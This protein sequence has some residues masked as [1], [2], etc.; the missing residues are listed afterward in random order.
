MQAAP[1]G[2][3]P[4]VQAAPPGAPPGAQAAPPGVP[5]A[6]GGA[7]AAAAGG[8]ASFGGWTVG[9]QGYTAPPVQRAYSAAQTQLALRRELGGGAAVADAGGSG[10]GYE[11]AHVVEGLSALQDAY[12]E[13]PAEPLDVAAIKERIVAALTATGLPAG[14]IDGSAADA[15]EVV[16]GLFSSLLQDALIASGAKEHLTR[17]QP[18]VHRAAL[19]DNR[20]FE[21]PDHPVRL[22]IDRVARLRDGKSESVQQRQARVRELIGRAN[23]EFR[24]DIGIFDPVLEEIESLLGEQES[25][26][27]DRVAAVVESCEEQQRVLE[28]R[29]GSS[30]ESTDSSAARSDLPEEWHKWLDRARLLEVG[31]RMLMNA[32]SARPLVVSLVWKEPRNNLFVFVDELGNKANTLTQQQVAMYLRRGILRALGEDAGNPALERAMFGVVD[33]F[34]RQVEEEATRDELTGFLL[35]RFFLEAIDTALPEPETASARNAAVCELAIDNLAEVN[36]AYGEAVGD[37]LLTAL[38]GE[39]ERRVRGRNTVF[40]RLGGAALG[41]YWPNGGVAGAERKL[42]TALDALR[43][44]VVPSEPGSS[45]DDPDATVDMKASADAQT[46]ARGVKAEFVIGLTGTDDGLV[47]AEG[48]VAAAHD[49]CAAARSSGPYTIHATGSETAQRRQLEQLVNYANKALDR[50]VLTLHGQT[51]RSLGESGVLPALHVVIGAVDRSDRPIPSH[52]FG[53]ALARSSAAARADRWAFERALAWLADNDGVLE[54]YALIIVPLS[55]MSLRDEDLAS[56]LM[57]VFMQVAVPPGR[58]CFELPDRDVVENVVGAGELI[59]TLKEFGCRFVL[60]DFGSGH[61]NYDYIKEVDV[62]FVSIKANF[63]IDASKS[64]KDFAMAKSINELVHFMGKKT[65]GKQAA[66]ADLGDTMREI[67]IDFVH[68]QVNTL[69][70]AGKS[71]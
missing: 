23:R 44:V 21:S 54:D 70:I 8:G 61:A 30:L 10:F 67:G 35:R 28:E 43:A 29:R 69:H 56:H 27:R 18:S 53:P 58:I 4:G 15:I 39:L 11:T 36:D 20:F 57:G 52:L 64:A 24:D 41:V 47:Q 50:D 26:Y 12:A 31:Q 55:S 33:R 1:P 38:A 65:I 45:D 60:D 62:D 51:V 6:V 40:G 37:A 5:D 25:E 2:P 46:V 7:M 42:Q 19:L 63:I 48:L 59:S 9:P 32:T 17:L 16:A 34:H 14:E 49:A 3:P 71:S 66:G 13:G 22:L 68:D